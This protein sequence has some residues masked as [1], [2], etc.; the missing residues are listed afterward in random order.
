M[1]PITVMGSGVSTG[2]NSIGS[3]PR[4]HRGQRRQAAG[5][6][7]KINVR[8]LEMHEDFVIEVHQVPLLRHACTICFSHVHNLRYA[9]AGCTA[10]PDFCVNTELSGCVNCGLPPRAVAASESD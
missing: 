2:N 6:V 4:V 8:W 3:V 10:R 5:A 9:L 1:S 7:I